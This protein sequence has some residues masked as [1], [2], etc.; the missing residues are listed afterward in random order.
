MN[1]GDKLHKKHNQKSS[2]HN[3]DD[4]RNDG[5]LE[6][7]SVEIFVNRVHTFSKTIRKLKESSQGR[8][9]NIY[10]QLRAEAIEEARIL[11]SAILSNRWGNQKG[12]RTSQQERMLERTVRDFESLSSQLKGIT[13]NFKHNKDTTIQPTLS[14]EE[15]SNFNEFQKNSLVSKLND[16]QQ[17]TVQVERQIAV[18]TY[19]TVLTMRDDYNELKMLSSSFI[20]AVDDQEVYIN[21]IQHDVTT[22]HN[23]IEIGVQEIKLTESHRKKSP[24]AILR[25]SH[26]M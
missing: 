13:N 22:S 17:S 4:S 25:L 21:K 26:L 1:W 10:I 24:L 9:S 3:T 15:E 5:D 16:W 8:R 23:N 20:D 11:K 6:C 12:I 18:E 2:I 14:E 7:M 19:E